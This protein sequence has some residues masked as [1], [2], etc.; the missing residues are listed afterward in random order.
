MK[1]RNDADDWVNAV[2]RLDLAAL[3][4]EWRHRA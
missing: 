1:R 4:T 2:D 3:A